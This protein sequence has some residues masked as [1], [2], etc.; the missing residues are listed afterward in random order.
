MAEAVI[1]SQLDTVAALGSRVYP[2][3]LPQNVTYPA[4]VYQRISAART[5]AFGRDSTATEATIQVDVYGELS[6]GYGSF[7]AL[8]EAVRAALQRHEGRRG[9]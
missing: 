5:S 8:T 1:K 3:V 6:S 9:L 7:H 4:A 2:L